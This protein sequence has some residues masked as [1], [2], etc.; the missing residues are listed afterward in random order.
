[1]NKPNTVLVVDD[2]PLNRDMLSRRLQRSGIAVEEAEDGHQAL[3][4]I[5]G[6]AYDLVLL[7]TMMPGLSGIEVLKLLRGTYTQSELPVI[8]VTALTE[9]ARIVEALNLGANDYV[10]KPVDYPVA[11][12]RIQSQLARKTAEQ[13][14]RESEERYALAERGANDGLWD[15][16]LRTGEVY[17]SAR[18]KDMLGFAEDEVGSTPEAWFDRVHPAD[19]DALQAA[20]TAHLRPDNPT[21]KFEHEYRIAQKG[22][23]FRW[24]LARGLAVRNGGNQPVRMTGWQ[25]DITDKK[26]YDALTGLPNRLLFTER[27]HL[28]LERARRDPSFLFAILFLDL[29]RFKLINDS[30]GHLAGDQLLVGI[31]QRLKRSIRRGAG[32]SEPGGDPVIARLGG[33]EFA[34]L[35]DNLHQREDAANVAERILRDL[36]SPFV[37]EGREV[38]CTTSIGIASSDLAYTS[39][40]DMVRDADTAMYSA[41]ALGGAKWMQ[42]DNAMRLRVVERLE[43]ESDLQRALENNEIAVHYQPKIRLA[44]EQICGFEALARWNHPTKGLISP[45]QFIPIAEETGLIVP[46]GLHVIRESCRQMKQW[47]DRYP[48]CRD[49]EISVNLSVKQ[50]RQ[51]DLCRQLAAV[52]EETGLDARLLQ[53]EVTETVLLD[54]FDKAVETVKCL[55]ALNV[56]LKIDDFGTGYSCL[57]YLSKLPFDTLKIDRSFTIDLSKGREADEVVRTI[58]NLAQTL[59]MDVVAE[60]IEEQDQA[61]LLRTMGCEYGQGFYFAKPMEPGTAERY[62]EAHCESGEPG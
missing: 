36:R 3:E 44:T 33:D 58:V 15:W 12:A 32:V 61:L 46:L 43:L 37:L 59:G 26:V 56:G 39:V 52:L 55:K 40:P 29:D 27:V 20:L 4:K 25:T 50:F 38:F 24:M 28:S 9:A 10:T 34:I 11:L 45:V 51:P 13:A 17:F 1:M 35:L 42:F 5:R 53:L 7:D 62:L 23:K 8:M 22:G 18:W 41:K 14:L 6:N 19:I 21:G 31:A 60:G 16:D 54:E 57:R 48:Q 49:L 30:L 47:H 2:E